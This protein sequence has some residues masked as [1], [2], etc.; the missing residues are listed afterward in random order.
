MT[1]KNFIILLKTTFIGLLGG[2]IFNILL[3]P[4]PWM[5]GPAFS[6]AIFALSGLHVNVSRNFRA[7]FVGVTGV[8]LGS[9]FQPNILNDI[10]IWFVSLIFLIL[11]VPFAHLIS[12][13]VL[14]KIRK[15]S[16]AE[17]FFIGSPVG[18][19]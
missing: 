16:K 18:L 8:W 4:L 7:P 10:N 13:Y 5:L 17:A 6:V 1:Y 19:L 15:I 12:Y 9:Y 11:Y 3:L 2:I 14:V